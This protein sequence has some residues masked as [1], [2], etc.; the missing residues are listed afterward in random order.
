MTVAAASNEPIRGLAVLQI[1]LHEGPA[2]DSQLTGHAVINEVITAVAD[3]RWPRLALAARAA[4]FG[5]VSAVPMMRR[6]QA[7]GVLLSMSDVA[8]P[9]TDEELRGVRALA[10][11][12]G[13]GI[14]QQRDLRRSVQAAEQLQQALDSRVLIEQAKG[15][16]AARLGIS[17]DRA[18][19]LLRGYAR[20]GNFTLAE[21]SAQAVRNALP[22]LDLLKA[23]QTHHGNHVRVPPAPHS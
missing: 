20:D 14:A 9:L 16:V 12:S 23:G 13:V 4:G 15:A 6:E 21:V 17:P 2:I 8:D 7:I 5:I 3:E 19:E 11:A 1:R 18:F 22:P 10:K